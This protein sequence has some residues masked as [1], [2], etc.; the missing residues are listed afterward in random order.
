MLLSNNTE[1]LSIGN[2][3]NSK[4]IINKSNNFK[5]IKLRTIS[6]K[7]ILDKNN[8]KNIDNILLEPK[9]KN[10]NNSSINHLEESNTKF[11]KDNLNNN[12]INGSKNILSFDIIKNKNN[13]SRK[14]LNNYLT[15]NSDN[16]KENKLN[17][18]DIILNKSNKSLVLMIE[19]YFII[20]GIPFINNIF[21]YLL[22]N[23]IKEYY[24]L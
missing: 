3:P 19:I 18:Q 13:F 1:N 4:S 5:D 8:N 2:I 6:N 23:K 14:N 7:N 21:I 20:I 24:S 16:K 22:I 9:S 12:S 15:N 17:L 10:T 11:F